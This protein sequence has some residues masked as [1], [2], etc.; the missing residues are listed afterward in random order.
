MR[1]LLHTQS[2][3]TFTGYVVR[4]DYK[5]LA[6]EDA[7][8][9]HRKTCRSAYKLLK[10]TWGFSQLTQETICIKPD[11]NQ[12]TTAIGKPYGSGHFAG[13]TPAQA[14]S[15]LFDQDWVLVTRAYFAFKDEA[16]A[17]QF[18]LSVNSNAIRVHIW[19]KLE[20]TI[21]EVV[22]DEDIPNES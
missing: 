2:K 7:E 8:K 17:L 13:M 20:F 15:S 3:L 14:I 9:E 22:E 11:Q 4:L 18:R 21:H 12:P 19:P 6:F 1:R 16:D 10:G 5:D